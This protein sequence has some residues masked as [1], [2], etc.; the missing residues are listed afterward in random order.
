MNYD[1]S[2][3]AILLLEDGTSF[4]GK[5][6]GKIGISGGE[7][8]FNTGKTGYQEIYTDPS[9]Y[10]QII[11]NTTSHI[12]NYGARNEEQESAYPQINGLV[13]NNFSEGYSRATAD[14]SLQE[15][16]ERNSTVGITDIATLKCLQWSRLSCLLKLLQKNP[17]NWVMRTR[18]LKLLFWT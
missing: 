14:E 1:T 10:G 8:C 12:G 13:V 4:Q 6:I 9:Y 7:I 18:V 3:S 15:Y 16:L 17:I 2:K 5:A 11:V